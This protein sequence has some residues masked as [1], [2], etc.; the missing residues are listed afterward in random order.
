MKIKLS[1][2]ILLLFFGVPAGRAQTGFS[3]LV[4]EVGGQAAGMG[5]AYS[6]VASTPVALYWNPA[7]L[8]QVTDVQIEVAHNK[9]ILNIMSDYLAIA[10]PVRTFHVGAFASFTNVGGIEYR[11]GPSAEPL[12]TIGET[13][14]VAGIG[15]SKSLTSWLDA[16]V[17]LKYLYYKIFTDQSWGFAFDVGT[18]AKMPIKGLKAAVVI[19]NLGGMTNLYSQEMK[20]PGQM[21]IGV[22]YQLPEKFMNG[23]WLFA[24]DYFIGFSSKNHLDFGAEYKIFN[25]LSLRAGYQTNYEIKSWHVG[26]GFRGHNWQ[27][28]YGFVPLNLGLA[29]GHR[30]SL[31]FYL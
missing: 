9:W 8:N 14:F 21:R 26:A 29:P 5:E 7:G 23:R 16:G 1:F 28:D 20:L 6:A 22:A 13:S 11:I 15:G 24:S 3:G 2:L 31:N 10:L 4:L 17:T 12:A 25:Q 18:Q 30:V 19:Q 27:I